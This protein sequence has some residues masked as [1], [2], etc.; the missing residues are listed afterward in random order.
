MWHAHIFKE[1]EI[2]ACREPIDRN[3]RLCIKIVEIISKS[4]ILMQFWSI[5]IKNRNLHECQY[6]SD[7]SKLK[8]LVSTLLLLEKV[9]EI[10]WFFTICM[11]ILSHLEGWLQGVTFASMLALKLDFPTRYTPTIYLVSLKACQHA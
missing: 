6:Q 5:H 2:R 7:F 10:A 1:K 4:N 9:G 8:A 3:K 11:I